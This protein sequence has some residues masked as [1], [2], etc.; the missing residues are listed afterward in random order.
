MKTILLMLMLFVIALALA[1][2]VI[3]TAKK[4]GR[5]FA[6]NA[7]TTLP[8]GRATLVPEAAFATQYLL[9]KRG[10]SSHQVNVC[11]ASDE[12]LCVVEDTAD[13]TDVTNLEPV[14]CRLLGS[15]Q[16]TAIAIASEAITIG[17]RLYTAANGKVQNEP[18][19]AGTYW[20]VGKATS[21]A[22][23]DG[24]Q[25]TFEPCLPLKLTVLAALSSTDG[26]AAAAAD[27]AALKAEAELIGDDLRAIA[28]ALA[29]GNTL[30]K[31]L[32]A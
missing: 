12:P 23:G 19:S 21:A 18:A 28:A 26:T 29:T 1:P 32:S 5:Q 8:E 6:A 9:G 4:L 14:S 7:T 17:Q 22:S 11:G 16:A 24:K 10:S 15:G 2:V 20:L 13:S 30:V 27:L 31:V 25:V 3:V